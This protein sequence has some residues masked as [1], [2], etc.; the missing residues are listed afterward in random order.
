M[1]KCLRRLLVVAALP[2]WLP[3]CGESEGRCRSLVQNQVVLPYTIWNP[4]AK[5]ED[6]YRRSGPMFVVFVTAAESYPL[7]V[8][9]QDD[10][11]AHVYSEGMVMI[12][13]GI[14]DVGRLGCPVEA[15]KVVQFATQWTDRMYALMRRDGRLH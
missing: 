12:P 14:D 2:L 13:V 9:S 5:A 7:T 11:R 3:A 1:V 15:E 10:F 8:L 6:F 4:R